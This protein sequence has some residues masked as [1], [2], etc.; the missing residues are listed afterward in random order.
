M[1]YLQKKENIT[2]DEE[3]M[4]ESTFTHEAASGE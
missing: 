1:Q 2:E 3:R 4:E